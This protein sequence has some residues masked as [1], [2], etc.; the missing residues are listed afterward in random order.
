MLADRRDRQSPVAVVFENVIVGFDGSPQAR[1][2]LTLAVAL[3]GHARLTVCCAHGFESLTSEVDPTQPSLSRAE[4][5]ACLTL[6]A[7]LVGDRALRTVPVAAASAVDALQRLAERDG[8]DLLVVGS[9]HR[10]RIGRVFPGS[11][12][13]QVLHGAPCPVAVASVGLHA[14]AEPLRLARVAVAYDGGPESKPTLQQAA[15]LARELDAR[16]QVVRIVSAVAAIGG[17]WAGAA[18]PALRENVIKIASDELH[19]TVAS[20]PG[21][22]EVTVDVFDGVAAQELLLVSRDCDLLV[23]GS[24][25][26]GPLRRLLLGSVSSKVVRAAACPVLVLARS[27][28]QPTPREPVAD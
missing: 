2:A 22:P 21:D 16:L 1:D 27:E 19:E 4:A 3:A 28:P 9:S 12:T 10:G 5:D 25:G 24:R 23:L 15:R 17:A 11:V 14:S 7:E 18:Y 20:L 13:E 6:A 26:Y 8:A